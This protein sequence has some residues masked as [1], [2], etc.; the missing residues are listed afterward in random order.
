MK[1]NLA[2]L[3]INDEK[4]AGC[5][6]CELSADVGS[7]RSESGGGSTGGKHLDVVAL[8]GGWRLLTLGGST[9]SELGGRTDQNLIVCFF[10]LL[11]N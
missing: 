9:G 7:G 6:Y 2:S 1:E 4:S 11:T 10:L 8:L 5:T 3:Q